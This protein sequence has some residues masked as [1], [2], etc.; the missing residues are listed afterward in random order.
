MTRMALLAITLLLVSCTSDETP[1]IG[2]EVVYLF[3]DGFE[4]TGSDLSKLFPSDGSRWSNIQVVNPNGGENM[5][6]LQNDIA[7]EGNTA[8]KVI[9]N[10]SDDIL[11]KADIEKGGF[12]A[13]SGSTVTLEASF[14]ITSTENLEN[15]LLIDLECCSCWDPSVPDNQCPGI[16]LMMKNN[17]HLSIE[18]GKILG[19]TLAQSSVHFP[20]NEWVNV[21]WELKLS[22]N[23]NG[24][25]RLFI[26]E[27]QVIS[28]NG[29]NM[30]NS[31]LFRDEFASN[32]VD[33]K[34]QEPLFYERFQIGATANPTTSDIELFVDNVRLEINE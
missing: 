1:S 34:L 13:P 28:E 21:R 27:Q 5:I 16:R 12:K 19:A 4:T 26:N 3:E 9:A 11:S 10:A 33:F 29:R 31:K 24:V 15:L 14:Y 8:L 20:R 23:E 32:G 2:S 25:N 17:D 18:R 6:S 30:P 7:I 22:S